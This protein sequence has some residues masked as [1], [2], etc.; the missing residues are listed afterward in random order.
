[1]GRLKVFS[2][3]MICVVLL[4]LQ[5]ERAWARDY[6]VYLLVQDCDDLDECLNGGDLEEDAYQ[7]LLRM[8]QRPIPLNRADALLLYDLP[9]LGFGLA[10]EIVAERSRGGV[11]KSLEELETRVPVLPHGAILQLRPFVMLGQSD[12]FVGR[13]VDFELHGEV[14]T[15]MV[16]GAFLDKVPAGTTVRSLQ[17]PPG[18]FLGVDIR[19][20]ENINVG[21]LFNVRPVADAWWDWSSALLASDGLKNKF[22]FGQAYAEYRWNRGS[23]IL[24]SFEAGFGDRLV[25]DT[26]PK[27]FPVGFYRPRPQTV[28]FV[29]GRL[30][31]P[32]AGLLG[33]AATF[34]GMS[35]LGGLMDTTLFA[36]Y[37]HKDLY[38]YDME[39]GVDEFAAG[40]DDNLASCE[41]ASAYRACF[42]NSDCP[43][44]YTCGVEGV[45]R[46]TKV[47]DSEVSGK[48]HSWL[49][50]RDVYSL[51]L[52][53]ANVRYSYYDDFRVDATIYR[54]Q[55]GF[56]VGSPGAARFA[57]S[58]KLPRRSVFGSA[59]LRVHWAVGDFELSSALAFD[60]GGNEAI[61]SRVIAYWLDNWDTTMSFRW[62]GRDF[63]N[64]FGGSEA[65]AAETLGSR[66]R[67][68]LGI[69]LESHLSL[70]QRIKLSTQLELFTLP[71][72]PLVGWSGNI[73]W[74]RNDAWN[75]R[76]SQ[77]AT[78]ELTRKET[79]NVKYRF[80]DN[81]LSKRGR[82]QSYGSCD[83]F[84]LEAS[85]LESDNG[86]DLGG[87]EK[88][89]LGVGLGSKRLPGVSM[90][91]Y[92]RAVLQDV[93]NNSESYSFSQF[94]V[95]RSSMK[96]WEGAR[97]SIRARLHLGTD[98]L[99]TADDGLAEVPAFSGYLGL[100]QKIGDNWA[101]DVKYGLY[102][103]HESETPRQQTGHYGKLVGKWMF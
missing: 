32:D 102:H 65:A 48:T 39:Y 83:S 55:T 80:S 63:D 33:V 35:A 38:Q 52:T 76:L 30:R 100:S 58:S 46:S 89:T 2:T 14:K 10:Q 21:T 59:G 9:G 49:T 43:F 91:A 37:D 87:G 97:L 53:G 56:L 51:F 41:D 78:L 44:G 92:Y 24:G 72:R 73:S 96:G 25:F 11:F 101:V 54:G 82:E 6:G 34:N 61:F 12:E 36:S 28:D 15:G 45:C 68:E 93:K 69:K 98:R 95:L 19:Y 31:N 20:E 22:D 50:L 84:T 8:C 27:A 18:S 64:P 70:V 79:A 23:F 81:D 60:D 16:G 86:C 99:T 88:H 75:L 57:L 94:L 66:R 7:N 29:N 13:T 42:G 3:W 74:V 71:W 77:G 4:G 90:G 26:T 1:M 62:Y 40:C 5:S 67:N 103:L 17:Y 47:V 85:D